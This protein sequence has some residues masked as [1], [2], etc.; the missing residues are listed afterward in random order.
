MNTSDPNMANIWE[1]I[2]KYARKAGKVAARPL[3]LMYYVLKNPETPS[4]D[5]AAII[6]ALAYIALPIN[7]IPNSIPILGLL[8]EGAAIMLAYNRVSRHVTPEIEREADDT[9][10]QWFPDEAQTAGA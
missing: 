1:N 4:G 5:K 6:G 10:R 2:S 8:D 7:I 9:L 3:L